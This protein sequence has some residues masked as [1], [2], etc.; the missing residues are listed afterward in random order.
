MITLPPIERTGLRAFVIVIGVGFGACVALVLA[1]T[2]MANPGLWGASAGIFLIVGGLWSPPFSRFLY[3]AW[4]KL[5]REF[6]R[7]AS[8]ILI[9][10]CYYTIFVAVGRTGSGI[11][12]TPVAGGT[13]MWFRRN[14]TLPSAAGDPRTTT[15]PT[16][17]KSWALSY[18]TWALQSRNIWYCFVLPF[19]LLVRALNDSTEQIV[20]TDIYTLY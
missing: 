15:P 1:L 20:P 10:I 6:S 9:R 2:R 7:R 17:E 14:S 19:V 11:C 13:S 4:N 12:L 8:T 3:R 16:G 18:V 5:A